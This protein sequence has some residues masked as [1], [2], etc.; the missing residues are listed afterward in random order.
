ML[1]L[2]SKTQKARGVRHII[3]M[4]NWRVQVPFEEK[5][6]Y[7]VLANCCYTVLFFQKK[8]ETLP[9]FRN[10]QLLQNKNQKH[11]WQAN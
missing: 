4:V 1:T 8:S 10:L 3:V 2:E 11:I 5:G 9:S 7:L 6:G